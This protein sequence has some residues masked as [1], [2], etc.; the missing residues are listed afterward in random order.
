MQRRQLSTSERRPSIP[1]FGRNLLYTMSL[2]HI[3]I[4]IEVMSFKCGKNVW[5]HRW[6]NQ[7]FARSAMAWICACDVC[8]RLRESTHVW[9]QTQGGV[10]RC[11]WAEVPRRSCI[12][13]MCMTPVTSNIFYGDI[14]FSR[15]S[16]LARVQ[17]G[18]AMLRQAFVLKLNMSI[19]CPSN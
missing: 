18:R 15:A 4:I 2:H 5:L 13:Q 14:T 3:Y 11:W 16:S 7:M 12:H 17:I 9:R 6:S 8:T 10:I 1:C 19:S